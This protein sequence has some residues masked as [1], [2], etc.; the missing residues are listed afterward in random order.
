[1]H[2]NSVWHL[3][4]INVGRLTAP[5]GDPRTA[6]FFGALDRIN[7]L[8]DASPGFVWR[9]QDESGNATAIH[10]AADPLFAVNMSVWESAAALFEFVYRSAHTPVMARRRE[11]FQRFEGH[12]QA[13]W[14]V[15]AGYRPTVDE[16][17]ARLWRLEKFGP[18]C[19]AFTFKSS[20]PPP[21]QPGTEVDMKPDPWCVGRA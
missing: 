4:Q 13:L 7:A 17:L 18:T 1:M 10:P 6:D 15:P 8:A 21:D 11:F 20:F 5:P 2:T 19:D 12:Y 16:G 14:W 3:A 9:L